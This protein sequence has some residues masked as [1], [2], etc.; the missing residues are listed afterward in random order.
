MVARSPLQK[1]SVEITHRSCYHPRQLLPKYPLAVLPLLSVLE[2][3]MLFRKS[4]DSN[5]NKSISFA[6]VFTHE[7][8]VIGRAREKR[9]VPQRQ[10]PLPEYI[11]GLS[12][13][14]GG[15]RSATFNLGVIQALAKNNLL[16]WIDYLST[17]SGGGYIGSLAGSWAY[18]LR[19][20]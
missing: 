17:V 12:F 18:S 2:V 7:L 1:N 14:G 20:H 6:D 3:A 15:I 4:P 10:R 11:V 5:E 13:S 16:T 19:P 8:D 9:Q